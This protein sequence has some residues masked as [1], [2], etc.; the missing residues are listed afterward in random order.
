[1]WPWWCKLPSFLFHFSPH[2]SGMVGLAAIGG[3]FAGPTTDVE[4]FSFSKLRLCREQSS[5]SHRLNATDFIFIFNSLKL[6]IFPP[7]FSTYQISPNRSSRWV[8]CLQ[9][10]KIATMTTTNASKLCLWRLIYRVTLLILAWW[11]EGLP[12]QKPKENIGCLWYLYHC[13]DDSNDL[14]AAICFKPGPCKPGTLY[15]LD[16]SHLG[17]FPLLLYYS[18]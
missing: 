2:I 16:M 1:M 9:G 10:S 6:G 11:T 5:V 12:G 7:F 17:C 18:K 13:Q 8:Y 4:M 3:L 14:L 15:A